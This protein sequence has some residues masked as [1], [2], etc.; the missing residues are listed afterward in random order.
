MKILA[1]E[2]SALT[3][4]VAVTEDDLLKETWPIPQE[5]YAKEYELYLEDIGVRI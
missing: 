4:S 1:I 3:A 5:D 2:A